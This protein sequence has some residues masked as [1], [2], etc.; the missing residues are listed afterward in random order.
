MD[1]RRLVKA[2]VLRN[3][4]YDVPRNQLLYSLRFSWTSMRFR[5]RLTTDEDRV[6]VYY[7][8]RKKYSVIKINGERPKRPGFVKLVV[9]S[10]GDKLNY[11]LEEDGD[12]SLKSFTPTGQ[13]V[14]VAGNPISVFLLGMYYRFFP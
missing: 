3:D 13:V 1:L 2:S 12:F 7:N 8:F 9:V 4:D 14:N 10:D 5:Q 11:E 6:N